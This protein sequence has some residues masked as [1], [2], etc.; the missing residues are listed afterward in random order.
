MDRKLWLE[1]FKNRQAV[2]GTTSPQRLC[3][4]YQVTSFTLFDAEP[5]Y[6]FTGYEEDLS[7][8][9]FSFTRKIE[10]LQKVHNQSVFF[11]SPNAFPDCAAPWEPEVAYIVIGGEGDLRLYVHQGA[12]EVDEILAESVQLMS[13]EQIE[14]SAVRTLRK[15]YGDHVNG[16]NVGLDIEIT[17]FSLGVDMLAVKGE[18]EIGEYIPVW[19]VSYSSGWKESTDYVSQDIIFLSAIDGAHVEPRMT[20][21]GLMELIA[22][23]NK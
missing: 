9:A 14:E 4:L 21:D 3:A 12:S 19:C 10:G 5:C 2:G 7:G 23:Y 17:S 13:I 8:W 16:Q 20:T 15:M 18:S 22:L 6:V 1:P 11:T